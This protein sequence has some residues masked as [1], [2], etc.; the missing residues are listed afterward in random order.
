MMGIKRLVQV[1]LPVDLAIKLRVIA[2]SLDRPVNDILQGLVEDFVAQHSA[3]AGFRST[4]RIKKSDIPKLLE[5]YERQHM[6]RQKRAGRGSRTK[7]VRQ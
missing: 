7:A 1:R 4:P 6:I 3:K 2:A 5:A